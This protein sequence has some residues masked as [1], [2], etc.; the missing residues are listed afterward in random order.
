MLLCCWR[1][2]GSVELLIQRSCPW[3]LE[4][5]LLQCPSLRNGGDVGVVGIEP[6]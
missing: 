1:M 6:W 4:V 2:A 5:L 3:Y